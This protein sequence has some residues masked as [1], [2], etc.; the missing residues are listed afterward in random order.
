VPIVVAVALAA[1]AAGFVVLRRSS[2]AP[3]G[4]RIVYPT[5]RAGSVELKGAAPVEAGVEAP[6]G[7]DPFVIRYRVVDAGVPDVHVSDE[8]VT[9]RPPFD[10]RAVRKIDG[11]T[12]VVEITTLGRRWSQQGE[13]TPLNV[14][15]PPA[16]APPIP[17]RASAL[18]D[19]VAGGVLE[20]R[21][22]R[23]VAG[24]R[25]QVFRSG[26]RMTAEHLS[27]PSAAT[28]VDS[29]VDA[30]GIVLEEV[31]VTDGQPSTRRLAVETQFGATLPAEAFVIPD[32]PVLDAKSG[33]G[34]T[35]PADP[36]VRL[37]GTLYEPAS[38]PAGFARVN[39]YNVIPPQPENFNDPQRSGYRRAAVT[40]VFVSGGDVIV[41]EQGGTLEG[42]DAFEG[43]AAGEAIDVAPLGPGE[44][45][46]S[47]TGA[48]VRVKL[49]GGRY[50]RL[51]GTV[52]LSAL[53][54]AAKSLTAVQG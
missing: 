2:P 54:E 29:C 34:V 28:H 24:R 18:A 17:V 27:P 25:C 38:L 45:Y 42:R 7:T 15:L 14:E 30:D 11:K 49:A 44:A 41:I 51:M 5:D 16:W 31:V 22:V 39:R 52:P 3:T 21:E 43:Q 1:G 6:A 35:K 8:T 46:F 23:E 12:D 50:L 37:P 47:G 20:R 33:G 53:V 40:D 4:A 13:A 19:A 10:V 9:V 36:A 26:E 48:E 32:G